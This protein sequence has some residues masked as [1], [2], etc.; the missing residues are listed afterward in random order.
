MA[1]T[2]VVKPIPPAAPLAPPVIEVKPAVEA[3]PVEIAPSIFNLRQSRPIVVK[4]K[5]KKR[6]K[7]KYSKSLKGL[8]RGMRNWTRAGDRSFSALSSGF[9]RFRKKSDRSSR[10]KR[11]GMLKDW[12]KNSA[13]G[14]GRTMRKGSKVPRLLSKAIRKKTVKRGFRAVGRVGRIFGW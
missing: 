3:K 2:T 7:R 13:S 6:K 14:V 10:K 5:G 8:G 1:E 4:V 11:D 9:R 12:V